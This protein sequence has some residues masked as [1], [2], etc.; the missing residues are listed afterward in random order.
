MDLEET[1]DSKINFKIILII[2]IPKVAGGC[3]SGFQTSKWFCYHIDDLIDNLSIGNLLNYQDKSLSSFFDEALT[4]QKCLSVT[5]RKMLESIIYVC[6][7]KVSGNENRA[8]QR[9]EILLK[10]LKD[11]DFA[12][13][14]LKNISR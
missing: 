13:V 12:M 10:L 2:Q 6:C 1:D 5:L 9:I 14:L 3:I 7:S 8:I 4:S 11:D